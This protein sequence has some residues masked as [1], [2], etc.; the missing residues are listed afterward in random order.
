MCRR[1][2]SLANAMMQVEAAR[3]AAGRSTANVGGRRIWA[4]CVDAAAYGVRRVQR[5][6][7]AAYNACSVQSVCQSVCVCVWLRAKRGA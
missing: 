1:Q 5:A 3:A 4:M 6:E 7:R 2:H